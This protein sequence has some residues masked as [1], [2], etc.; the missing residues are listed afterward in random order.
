MWLIVHLKS[1]NETLQNETPYTHISQINLQI[2]KSIQNINVKCS[3]VE[4]DND[5]EVKSI[6]LPYK[7]EF[8]IYYFVSKFITRDFNVISIK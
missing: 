8:T 1:K 4:T 3:K 7:T 5:I 6:K 2:F